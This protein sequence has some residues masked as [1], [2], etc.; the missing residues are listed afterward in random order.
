M[1]R[2]LL[3]RRY[4]L[5]AIL[6]LLFFTAVPGVHSQDRDIVVPPSQVKLLRTIPLHSSRTEAPVAVD[7]NA[8]YSNVTTFEGNAFVNAGATLQS[9]NTITTLLADSLGLVGTPPFTI[10]SFTFS[11]ANFDAA[12]VTAR[13]RIRFYNADGPAGSPGTL[14]TGI[15]FSPILFATGAIQLFDTGPLATTFPVTSNGIWAGMTFDDNTGTTGATAAQLNNL[16]QGFFNPVDKGSSTDDLFQTDT[17]GSFLGDN[18]TGSIGNLGGT[19]VANFGW[20]IISALPLPVTLYNFQAQKNGLVNT[21]S[22]ST[23]QEINSNNFTIE[24]S[25]DAVRFTAIGRV[26]AAGNSST[27]RSYRFDDPRPAGGNNYYRLKMTDID[28]A[29]KYSNIVTVKN[30]KSLN[31]LLYP[32]PVTNS[33][34]VSLEVEQAGPGLVNITGLDGRLVYHKI[35][36]VKAGVNNI[37]LDVSNFSKGTYNIKVQAGNIS[38]AGTFSKL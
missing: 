11:V 18:P 26:K 3:S 23:S 30:A 29:I 22:W 27:Q 36:D 15:S 6:T 28:N 38:S 20:E 1:T 35:I 2:T 37:P 21:L 7:P 5:Q 4:P 14:I 32:N 10:G 8:L 19:P 13:P 9:G 33:L 25:V 12:D 24:R 17:A 31:F 16:G 34:V